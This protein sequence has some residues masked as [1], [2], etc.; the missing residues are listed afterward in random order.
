MDDHR[1]MP[2]GVVE[3]L[4]QRRELWRGGPAAWDPMPSLAG[5]SAMPL[6]VEL[7][8]STK[9]EQRQRAERNPAILPAMAS[10]AA[11]A[12]ALMVPARAAMIVEAASR[13]MTHYSRRALSDVQG[14][15]WAEDWVEDLDDLPEDIVTASC[16]A[17]RRSGQI[18]APTSGTV[19]SL[20]TP[21]MDARRLYHRTMEALAR[22][23]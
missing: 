15:A 14:R 23:R 1:T 11:E 4:L 10:L 8:R 9:S 2:R 22:G 21:V 3:T 19:L 18:A 5:H 17:Y 13:L 7:V 16:R 20:A 12:A 6:F